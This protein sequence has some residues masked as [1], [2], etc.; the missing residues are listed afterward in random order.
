MYLEVIVQI[1]LRQVIVAGRISLHY[2]PRDNPVSK[3]YSATFI[4]SSQGR[5]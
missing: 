3:Y 2:V 4:Q 1:M 5:S